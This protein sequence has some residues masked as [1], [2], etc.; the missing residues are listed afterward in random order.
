MRELPSDRL[1]ALGREALQR[2]GVDV[3]EF[4]PEYVSAA[5]ETCKGKL[6]IFN[7]LPSYAGFYFSDEIKYDAGG[8]AKHFVPENRARLQSVRDAFAACEPFDA[9]S[10]EATLKATAS[11]L[12]GK[13]GILVHP[14]RL[15]VTGATAGPSL[16]HLLEVLGREKVLQ[17]IDL[18]LQH[19]GFRTV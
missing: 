1:Q 4:P 12:G 9:A 7:E 15:A 3:S 14:T 2:G 13:V 10:I 11:A 17:R 19:P 5:L 16:Y 18:A 6:R 8:V